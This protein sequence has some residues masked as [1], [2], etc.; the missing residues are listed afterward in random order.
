MPLFAKDGDRVWSARTVPDGR[1]FARLAALDKVL[2]ITMVDEF[3]LG[4]FVVV[5]V[6]G[7]WVSSLSSVVVV[8]VVLRGI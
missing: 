1:S 4:L 2:S 5:M 8:F 6:G 7:D 3:E